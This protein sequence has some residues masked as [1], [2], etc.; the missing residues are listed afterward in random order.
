MQLSLRG[1]SFVGAPSNPGS[2][3]LTRCRP[4]T[5]LGAIACCRPTADLPHFHIHSS[6]RMSDSNSSG[7]RG[8]GSH[9]RPREPDF[10]GSL[11]PEPEPEPVDHEG[12]Q[13]CSNSGCRNP[14]GRVLPTTWFLG[15][16]RNR[17]CVFQ[18][19]SHCRQLDAQ[20]KKQRRATSQ[21]NKSRIRT[22]ESALAEA[23]RRINELTEEN[24]KLR[25]AQ[26]EAPRED[27]DPHT[28][29]S[30]CAAWWGEQRPQRPEHGGVQLEPHHGTTI[31]TLS[32]K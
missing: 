17:G 18:T 23:T 11:A 4:T 24:R 1:F 20:K 8:A 13:T 6:E 7:E 15:S 3:D 22:L 27:I 21:A 14:L 2:R 19:C 5:L 9:K 25:G 10:D 29:L 30:K 32:T 26:V 12:T 16:L 31:S 28:A